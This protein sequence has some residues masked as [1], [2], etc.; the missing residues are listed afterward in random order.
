MFE[1]LFCRMSALRC[2]LAM[3]TALPAGTKVHDLY[4]SIPTG[5]YAEAIIPVAAAK[6]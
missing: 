3:F 4:F 5:H 2:D 6:P 1:Q